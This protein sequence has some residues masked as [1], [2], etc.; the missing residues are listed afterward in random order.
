M[1][2]F[3]KYYSQAVCARD[4]QDERQPR[5]LGSES[6]KPRAETVK[7]MLH[8]EQ[9]VEY[10]LILEPER[11]NV[12]IQRQHRHL[13]KLASPCSPASIPTEA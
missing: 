7:V 5:F 6:D 10:A 13:S 9:M 11:I 3:K 12:D 2:I 1:T 8:L 4:A